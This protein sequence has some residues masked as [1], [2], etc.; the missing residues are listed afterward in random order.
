MP[1]R[2]IPAS[3]RAEIRTGLRGLTWSFCEPN[4][5]SHVS[6]WP[7]AHAA[8]S[9]RR[10]DASAPAAVPVVAAPVVPLT[11]AQKTA[12][13]ALAAANLTQANALAAAAAAATVRGC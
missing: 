8:G 13:D 5:G 3:L 7:R 6:F 12:A 4:E 1:L 9:G 11:A 10:F 2:L